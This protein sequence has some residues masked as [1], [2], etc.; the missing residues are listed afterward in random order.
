MTNSTKFS[1]FSFT[2]SSL[3][4]PAKLLAVLVIHLLF[5]GVFVC[6]IHRLFPSK[7][8]GYI[9]IELDDCSYFLGTIDNYFT[10]GTI[11]EGPQHKPFAGRMPGYGFPYLLIR[12]FS[13]KQTGMCLLLCFQALFSVLA[14]VL[15][16]KI[17]EML[18]HR[19]AL[20]H[21]VLFAYA[22]F[23]PVLMYDVLTISE[24]LSVSTYICFLFF[25]CRFY[26]HKKKKD[27]LV[28]GFFLGWIIFLRPF[29]GIFL[30]L[31]GLALFIS[32]RTES[33][34][35][36]VQHGVLLFAGF[37]L[38]ET[39]WIARN[40][41][42][43]HRFIPLETPLNES[44]GETGIYRKSALAIRTFINSWGGEA[45]EFYAGSHAYWFQYGKAADLDSYRFP[46]RMF[47]VIP[48][49]SLMLLKQCF[50]RSGN[51]SLPLAT[52]DSCNAAA[53]AM[54]LRFASRI[55]AAY[56]LYS[57][58]WVPVMHMFS[59][60]FY[61]GTNL[62]ILPPF[63][64]M[65]PAEK[66]LK[67]FSWLYYYLVLIGGMGA[68]WFYLLR[69]KTHRAFLLLPYALPFLLAA[70]IVLHSGNYQLQPRYYLTALPMYFVFTAYLIEQGL[71][72]FF[73]KK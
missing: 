31:L 14:N 69:V 66:A 3:H 4:S 18:F 10:Y 5:L 43:F 52:T 34:W 19:P 16:A 2:R 44:Y 50:D 29:M 72:R 26:L 41:Y 42:T 13:N 28:A 57:H 63:S 38:M 61:N 7:V 48:R 12:L 47:R 24:S 71:W 49:D 58:L 67:V 39:A 53:E 62:M 20:S 9:G 25:I 65:N 6:E 55:K 30:P 40:A 33:L 8:I 51:F 54:A 1:P 68:G 64:Q 21:G 11:S 17:T 35:W 32:G 60:L 56:P 73:R 15:L 45:G 59:S 37:L 70:T 22:F 36:K 27:L 46:E 23:T